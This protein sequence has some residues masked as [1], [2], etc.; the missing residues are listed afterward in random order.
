MVAYAGAAA[1]QPQSDSH[2]VTGTLELLGYACP[3]SGKCVATGVRSLGGTTRYAGLLVPVSGGKPGMVRQV[4][5]TQALFGV[6]CPRAN[7]CIATA[8]TGS[9]SR[10]VLIPIANGVPGPAISAHMSTLFG[11]GCATQ[12]SCWATGTST[13]GQAAVVHL[14]GS[15]PTTFNFPS[16]PHALFSGALGTGMLCAPDNSCVTAG[17]EPNGAP[18]VIF[19][20]RGR[21][22]RTER[23]PM[24]PFGAGSFGL[25]CATV[26]WCM[27][28]GIAPDGIRNVLVPVRSGRLGTPRHLTTQL[29][30]VGCR[31][32]KL[33]FGFGLDPALPTSSD[34]VA[35]Q[36][37]NGRPGTV[38]AAPRNVR[39]GDAW[40]VSTRCVVVGSIFHTHP[41]SQV[42]ALYTLK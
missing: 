12:R 33:C 37:K 15:R 18:L 31:S 6:A 36:I 16:Q 41:N 7:H 28:F 40:C 21:I 13:S 29:L 9:G 5:N 26:K 25:T 23:L 32:T 8:D 11:I 34:D 10:G 39:A 4:A 27:A 30:A 38:R 17:E 42:G 14:V 2:T 35:I 20:S 22:I 1:A 24:A 3:P 19:L